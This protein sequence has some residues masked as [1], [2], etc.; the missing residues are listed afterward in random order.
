MSLDWSIDALERRAPRAVAA[1]DSLGG[2][3]TLAAAA[4]ARLA[5]RPFELSALVEQLEAMGTRSISVAALTAVFSC[6]VMTAQFTFQMT[7]FGAQDYVGVV[8]SLSQVRELGPVLTALI[9]GGRIGAGITAELGAMQVTEQIDAMRSMG[10]DPVR[11]LVLPRILAGAVLLPILTAGADLVGIGASMLMARIQA[12]VTFARSYQIVSRSV[13]TADLLG[14]LGKT[15]FF[16]AV[17]TLIACYQ[18]LN[19]TG[20]TEGVGRATT[21]AVVLTSVATLVGEF[22]LT[23]IL[24][25]FGV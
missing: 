17:I 13:T 5:R 21:R 8:V 15:V 3:A 18:G 10:A 24:L 16:G 22:V 12:G 19:A 9:V 4:G 11:K 23:K 20:G 14:G 7:R 1:L 25:L 6:M 2:L